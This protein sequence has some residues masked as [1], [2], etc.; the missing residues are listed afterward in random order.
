MSLVAKSKVGVLWNSI[1]LLAQRGV[2]VITTLVLAY[3][4]APEDFGLLAMIAIFLAIGTSLMESGFRQ[5]LIRQLNVESVDFDTAFYSNLVL[6]IL[7]YLILYF[8]APFIA[9][10]YEEQRLTLIIRVAS[11]SI[12]IQSLQVIQVARLCRKLDFKTQLKASL[13]SNLISGSVAIGLAIWLDAGVWSLV[14]QILIASLLQTALLYFYVPWL[15][16]WRFSFQSLKTMYG[17]GYKLFLASLLDTIFKNIYVSVIAKLFT[18][19]IAGYYFFANKIKELVV[20]QIV[21]AIQ[22]V[23]FPAMALIQQDT[24]R[25]KLAY[26]RII[27][28]STYILFPIL[29]YLAVL[30]DLLFEIFLPAAWSPAVPYLQIMCISGLMY[31]LHSINLN[32][33]KVK[34]RSDLFLFIEVI[35]KALIVIGLLISWRYGVYGI[36]IGQVMVSFISYIPNS[37]FSSRLIGYSVV[38]QIKDIMPNLSLTV[39]VSAIGIFSLHILN[40]NILLEFIIVSMILVS[41]YLLL[42]VLF[43]LTAFHDALTVLKT[44]SS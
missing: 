28:L 25:L 38:E 2:A 37:Y 39:I 21:R 42:S 31:P 32:I 3:F 22:T 6:G 41:S 10:F 24:S 4:L 18:A 5:A 40:V 19:S 11:I 43:K 29:M 35:K 9:D 26:K 27:R 1:E 15:P 23:T 34:G 12:L 44:K 8:C 17:F 33:L 14:Y 7:S 30:A 13:P 36:L 20:T 16:K